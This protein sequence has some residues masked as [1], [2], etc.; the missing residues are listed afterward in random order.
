[1]TYRPGLTCRA[2]FNSLS[3]SLLKDLRPEL[4]DSILEHA[5]TPAQVAVLTPADLASAERAKEIEAAKQAVLQQTVKTKSS[6]AGAIRLGRDGLERV[7]DFRE[8][9]ML[10]IQIAEREARDTKSRKESNLPEGGDIDLLSETAGGQVVQ[11]PAVMHHQ[12][13]MSAASVSSTPIARAVATP[14]AKSVV[15]SPGPPARSFSLSSAWADSSAAVDIA[16]VTESFGEDQNQLDLSDIISEPQDVGIDA[17]SDSLATTGLNAIPI[18]WS[19]LV[20]TIRRL[21]LMTDCQQRD[22]GCSLSPSRIAPHLLANGAAGLGCLA[23]S[24]RNSH[25]RAGET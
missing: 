25:D 15:E 21:C 5:L 19:G 10:A 13:S 7:E 17:T 6:E 4:R 1:M 18:V 2:Q 23:A 14:I 24:P 16:A 9:E 20:R 11:S 3:S 8:K 12:R 22:P